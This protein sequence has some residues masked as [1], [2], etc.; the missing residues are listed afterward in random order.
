MNES[1]HDKDERFQPVMHEEASSHL[2]VDEEPAI[3]EAALFADSAEPKRAS[4]E[5]SSS[6]DDTS[7]DENGD[8]IAS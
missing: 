2:D 1:R 4:M 7:D 3:A 6:C 5:K 8:E